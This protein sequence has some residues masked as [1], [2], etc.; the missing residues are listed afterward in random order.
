[1]SG[2]AKRVLNPNYGI[3]QSKPIIVEPKHLSCQKLWWQIPS[4]E[5]KPRKAIGIEKCEMCGTIYAWE[6][7]RPETCPVCVPLLKPKRSAKVMKSKIV[8]LEEVIK[9]PDTWFD[10]LPDGGYSDVSSKVLGL[11]IKKGNQRLEISAPGNTEFEGVRILI[12]A[13]IPRSQIYCDHHVTVVHSKVN[14]IN[15]KQNPAHRIARKR[16]GFVLG[17]SECVDRIKLFWES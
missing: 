2:Y 4:I 3:I 12:E 16:I 17:Q 13:N 15:R 9:I 11:V 6:L 5:D 10:E 8:K 14:Y 1:M 7:V